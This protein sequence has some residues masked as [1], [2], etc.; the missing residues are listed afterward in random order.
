[1]R[2]TEKPVTEALVAECWRATSS[3]SAWMGLAETRLA[4]K[5]AE[6]MKTLVSFILE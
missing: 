5:A 6:A 3:F 4:R 1:L 2:V